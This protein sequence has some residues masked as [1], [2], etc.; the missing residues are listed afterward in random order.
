ME[1]LLLLGLALIVAAVFGGKN[2]AQRELEQAA[3]EL[4][5]IAHS[6]GECEWC[7]RNYAE[8]YCEI[9]E[10]PLDEPDLDIID[11]RR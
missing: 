1:I 7:E 8:C 4:E 9:Y 3:D 11:I 10:P 5:R 2:S 6:Y